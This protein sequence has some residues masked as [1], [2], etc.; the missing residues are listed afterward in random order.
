MNFTL[1]VVIKYG[2]LS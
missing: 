1:G 2:Q